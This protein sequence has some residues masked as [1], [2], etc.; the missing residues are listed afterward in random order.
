M[1]PNGAEFA[2]H[3]CI[4]ALFQCTEACTESKTRADISDVHQKQ[5]YNHTSTYVLLS[6][7]TNEAL[8]AELS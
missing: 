2:N 6:K 8:H 7:P 3:V 4:D 5:N 1:Y